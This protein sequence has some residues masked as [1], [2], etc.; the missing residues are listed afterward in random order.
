MTTTLGTIGE[1]MDL[2]IRQGATFG[3]FMFTMKAPKAGA[4]AQADGTY[5][6]ADLL[7]IDLTGCTLRGQIRKTPADVAVVASLAVTVTDAAGGSY[8]FEL[9]DETTA[10]IVAGIDLSKRESIYVW[11]FELQDSLGRVIP[12]YWGEVRVFREVTRV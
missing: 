4:V 12:L 7:P 1:R 3:P 2:L 6:D 5:A 9:T 8:Q 10:T 11:D